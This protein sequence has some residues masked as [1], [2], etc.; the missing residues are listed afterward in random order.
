MKYLLD[1]NTCIFLMKGNVDVLE[2]YFELR[3][4]GLA[5]SS[6]TVAELY[7]GVYNSCHVEKNGKNLTNFLI[8]L[9]ILDVDS[10]VAME[11]GRICA[12]LRKKGTP[13]GQLDMFIAAHALSKGLILVTNNTKEFERIDGLFFE[14]WMQSTKNLTS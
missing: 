2:R 14:D 1:T 6:I 13:I 11:Y 8:G 3:D 12:D 5:I 7:Y 10:G 4:F 9:N